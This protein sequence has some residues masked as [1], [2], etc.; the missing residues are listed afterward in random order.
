MEISI[1]H[2]IVDALAQEVADRVTASLKPL[3]SGRKVEPQ[4]AILTPAQLAQYLHVARQW[5]Y[6]RVSR[7]EIPYFKAGGH[8]RFRKF[9][10]DKWIEDQSR[11][12]S[13]PLSQGLRVIQRAGK[14]R[15]TT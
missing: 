8:L 3:L 9:E 10:I 15:P 2:E 13:N 6:E 4:D 7:G 14:G 11:P 5:V 1:P 12:T